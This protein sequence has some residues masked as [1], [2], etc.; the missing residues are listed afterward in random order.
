MILCSCNVLS[1]AQVRAATHGPNGAGRVAEVFEKLGARPNCGRCAAS[2]RG[3]IRGAG[4]EALRAGRTRFCDGGCC[5][6]EAARPAV[7]ANEEAPD[8][9]APLRVAAE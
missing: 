5:P 7:V 6:S 1:E 4:A 3:V 8:V 2:I 9:G